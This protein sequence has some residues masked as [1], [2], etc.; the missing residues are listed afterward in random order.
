MRVADRSGGGRGGGVWVGGAPGVGCFVFV[1]VVDR[2][3][4]NSIEPRSS[5]RDCLAQC[6]THARPLRA[7]DGLLGSSHLWR[8]SESVSRPAGGLAAAGTA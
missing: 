4:A 3:M 6:G 1:M 7:S 2:G 5:D 8:P